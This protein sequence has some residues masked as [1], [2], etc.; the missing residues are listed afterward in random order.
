MNEKLMNL[1]AN[2]RGLFKPPFPSIEDK[3][4]EHANMIRDLEFDL[5]NTMEA[6]KDETRHILAVNSKLFD[7]YVEKQTF[8]ILEDVVKELSQQIIE[9][10]NQISVKKYKVQKKTKKK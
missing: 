4:S 10:S 7:S 3:V 1:L 6:Q 8:A 9:L 5:K 2:L